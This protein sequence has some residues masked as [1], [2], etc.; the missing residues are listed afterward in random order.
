MDVEVG[1]EKQMLVL[2]TES[3]KIICILILPPCQPYLRF[4]KKQ[5]NKKVSVTSL[6]TQLTNDIPHIFFIKLKHVYLKVKK[7]RKGKLKA[8][9]SI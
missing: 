3:N 1:L 6:R 9:L 4:L 2:L 7:K 8:T 5:H